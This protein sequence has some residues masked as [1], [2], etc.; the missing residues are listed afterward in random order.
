LA[1][2]IV[3][4]QFGVSSRGRP[5]LLGCRSVTLRFDVVSWSWGNSF[6][7]IPDRLRS[8][9]EF[10]RAANPDEPV[11]WR[12]NRSL[13]ANAWGHYSDDGVRCSWRTA[14]VGRCSLDS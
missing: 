2:S 6:R 9:R 11:G 7:T 3:L 14:Q 12:S 1:F 8:K 5:V 13:P 4:D 10:M